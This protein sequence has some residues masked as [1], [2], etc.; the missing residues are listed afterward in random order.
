[1]EETKSIDRVDMVLGLFLDN[2]KT[3]FLNQVVI[4]EQADDNL[5]KDNKQ[6]AVAGILPLLPQ[7]QWKSPYFLAYTSVP[8]HAV[9]LVKLPKAPRVSAVV[10]NMV[11]VM[12]VVKEDVKAK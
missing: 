3:D 9:D 7:E 4:D 5:K 6:K 10:E 1:M 2:M 12:V 11:E 8:K